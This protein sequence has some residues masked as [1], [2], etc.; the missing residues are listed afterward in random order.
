MSDLTIIFVT[1][2]I[3]LELDFFGVLFC[4]E[5]SEYLH[6]KADELRAKAE[7]I[8]H[9]EITLPDKELNTAPELP[10]TQGSG[11]FHD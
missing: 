1:V 4:S 2:I 6:A 5:I 7:T 8:R 3:C 10:A 11:E 9:K